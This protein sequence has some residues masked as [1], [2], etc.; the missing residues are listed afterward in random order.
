M[1][2]TLPRCYADPD[3]RTVVIIG[4]VPLILA[5]MLLIYVTWK[6]LGSR[7]ALKVTESF[8]LVVAEAICRQREEA[9]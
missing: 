9:Q 1:T 5:D 3:L 7:D 2:P 4:R 8:D 6:T